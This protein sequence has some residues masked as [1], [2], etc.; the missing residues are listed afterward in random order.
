MGYLVQL[1]LVHLIGYGA[2]VWR[3]ARAERRR[4]FS[5]EGTNVFPIGYKAGEYLPPKSGVST[6]ILSTFRLENDRATTANGGDRRLN[7]DGGFRLFI[8]TK[9]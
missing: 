1:T 5:P 7:S 3:I 4:P 8:E 2:I 9:T 6:N